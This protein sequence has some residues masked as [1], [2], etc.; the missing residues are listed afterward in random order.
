MYTY[1]YQREKE[2]KKEEGE[3]VTAAMERSS[4]D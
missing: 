4:F 1:I 2:R 3:H